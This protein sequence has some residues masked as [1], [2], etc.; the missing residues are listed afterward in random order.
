MS[1]QWHQ[2]KS[3]RSVSVASTPI[4]NICA[5]N[6]HCFCIKFPQ[7][8]AEYKKSR[9]FRLFVALTHKSSGC[10]T[11]LRGSLLRFLQRAAAA[12]PP[13]NVTGDSLETSRFPFQQKL[14]GLTVSG[15]KLPLRG[16]RRV[17]EQPVPSAHLKARSWEPIR[18]RRLM[19]DRGIAE[20]LPWQ[21]SS[22]PK[23]RAQP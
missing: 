1:A 7:I 13:A 17:I 16:K 9:G 6:P 10:Y 5:T 11:K 8:P 15:R 2:Y 4:C 18:H 23:L 19:S 14:E 3:A 21:T 12:L 20:Q 22:I